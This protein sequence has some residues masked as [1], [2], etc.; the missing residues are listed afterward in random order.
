MCDPAHRGTVRSRAHAA[1]LVL[2][3]L[4]LAVA[5]SHAAAAA[6]IFPSDRWTVRDSA[7]V[8]GK[9]VHLP[10]AEACPSRPSD[11]AELQRLNRLD[12][13][14]V[15]PRVQVS[16]D[17]RI[18]VSHVSART[19]S[20]R[21][22]GGGPAIGLDRLVW[23]PARR[24]LTGS[25]V[26]QL[27]PATRYRVRVA[28]ALAGTATSDTFTTMSTTVQL[29]RMAAG[30]RA[31]QACAARPRDA[32]RGH[33]DDAPDRPRRRDARRRARAGP[34]G[35]R[36][37]AVR[38]RHPGR[39]HVAASGP[40]LRD[41]A[42][43]AGAGA[44]G[45]HEH[46]VRPHRPGRHA[47]V[48]RLARRHLRP[49]LPALAL[50]RLPR[51][52]RERGARRRHHRDRRR[53]PRRRAARRDRRRRHPHPRARARP[54]H[55]RRRRDQRSR[56]PP[57]AAPAGPRRVVPAPRRPAPE[58]AGHGRARHRAARRRAGAAAA[59]A[60]GHHLLRPEP[61]RHLRH[62]R[63][64]DRA[65]ARAQRAQRSRRADDRRRPP[66]ARLPAP[67]PGRARCPPPARDGP[68]GDARRAA[69]AARRAA[70]D[71]AEPPRCS[72]PRR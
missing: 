13:F 24:I 32:A 16:F 23:D 22:A 30:V 34:V 43:E 17:R 53:R 7:Q 51:G 31:S 63:G 11:C 26:R 70:G 42:D 66:V 61:G 48:R 6:R 37:G 3:A 45:T 33:A 38:V 29:R 71:R 44:A 5:P 72:R 21:A 25:P 8:T 19:L 35:D 64:G 4:V 46:L 60:D 65:A 39:P 56:E 41:G 20:L 69:P 57:H 2:A 58:R 36:R 14:D 49:R 9:R 28:A 12:G 27:R 52:P 40:H 68:L 18:D 10:T 59:L 1:R 67:V 62:D 47:A 55:G 50:R 54:R 15:E